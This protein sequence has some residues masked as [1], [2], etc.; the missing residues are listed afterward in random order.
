[1]NFQLFQTDFRVRLLI[2][3]EW[4][5]T[6]NI[7]S[8]MTDFELELNTTTNS[9]NCHFKV[10]TYIWFRTNDSRQFGMTN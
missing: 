9:E 2:L 7:K 6:Y 10:E 1:M 5:K 3:N 4:Q 8:K